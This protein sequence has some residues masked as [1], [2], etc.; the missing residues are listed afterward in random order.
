MG[1]PMTGPTIRSAKPADVDGICRVAEQGWTAAY[2]GILA[3]ETIDRA[4]DEWYDPDSI[5]ELIDRNEVT[6]LVAEDEGVV[7]YASGGPDGEGDV[8]A[9]G[10]IYVDPDRW[11]E[12]IGTALLEAFERERRQAGDRA[13]RLRVLAANEVGIPFYRDRGY[14]PVADREG[15]LFGELVEERVFR[16]DLE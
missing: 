13:V 3:R 7:G 10:A 2:D 4:I 1:E 9:L 16:R 6:Y 8:A 11:G 5:R 14:E 12:G 15:E